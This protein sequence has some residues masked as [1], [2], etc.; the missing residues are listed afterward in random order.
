VTASA[1]PPPR[2]PAALGLADLLRALH[3][4]DGD[5]ARRDRA[6]AELGYVMKPQVPVHGRSEIAFQ[7]R[8]GAAGT[9]G[10][11]PQAAAGSTPAAPALPLWAV[12]AIGPGLPQADPDQPDTPL[13]ADRA[14]EL[15][16]CAPL[17]S[18]PPP[19]MP[20]LIPPARL[21]A[22]VRRSL[23]VP[24][25]TG[26]DVPALV[27]E[28]SRARLPTRLP[29]QRRM[30]RPGAIRVLWDRG[31]TML[32]YWDDALALLKPL[33]RHGA[34]DVWTLRDL[35]DRAHGRFRLRPDGRPEPLPMPSPWLAATTAPGVRTL[36]FSH[37]GALARPT[38]EPG[39]S[40]TTP[41]M[42][43][44][45]HWQAFL[46][47]A[48]SGGGRPDALPVAWVPCAPAGVG[49]GL[50]RATAVHS[51]APGTQGRRLRPAA[52]LNLTDTASVRRHEQA[53]ARGLEALRARLAGAVHVS[54]ALLRRLRLL[55]VAEKND[56]QPVDLGAEPG[57]EG[58]LWADDGVRRVAGCITL[59]ALSPSAASAADTLAGASRPLKLALLRLLTHE[60][61]HLGQALWAMEWLKLDALLGL[62]PLP[63]ELDAQRTDALRFHQRLAALV[64][65]GDAAAS[66]AGFKD[67]ASYCADALAR[68]RH[69]HRL[70]QHHGELLAPI[71]VGAGAAVGTLPPGLD[72]AAV[73]RFTLQC[74]QRAPAVRSVLWQQGEDLWLVPEAELGP[75][76]VKGAT[77]P[78]G[79]R[80]YGPA[81]LRE[82]SITGPEG[83]TQRFAARAAPQHLAR[84]PPSAGEVLKLQWA[85]ETLTLAA[86]PPPPWARETGRDRH[87]LYA[88][89]AIGEAVQRM[90]WIEPG[91]FWMGSPETEMFRGSDEGPRHRV[92]IASGYWLAD[93]VCT[94][95]FW[96]AAGGTTGSLKRKLKNAT[97]RFGDWQSHPVE[98]VSWHQAQSFLWQAQRIGNCLL[99]LPSEA[100][101][102]YACRAGTE[103]AY[104]FGDSLSGDQANFLGTARNGQAS[105][106]AAPVKTFAPNGW[107]LYGMHGNV[108]E[109]CEDAYR[110]YSFV[111]VT[112]PGEPSNPGQHGLRPTRGGSRFAPTSA[113]RSA[114]RTSHFAES[115]LWDHGF[116]FALR[117]NSQ[118]A[119]QYA[120]TLPIVP[121]YA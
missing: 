52:A 68:Q 44:Q 65:G 113:A 5:A 98:E 16:D 59:D 40:A 116:R 106:H 111:P 15:G 77:W 86:M 102:E 9:L 31:D 119:H 13:P 71:V 2:N 56:A 121:P 50:A 80:V 8:G 84:L 54:P 47:D 79:S 87:G 70:F 63:P 53:L 55:P 23:S 69:D 91:V 20:P 19:P 105:H 112:N 67:L 30:A 76:G 22:A 108:W 36:V 85:G 11:A 34:L 42:L 25:E 93:T 99:E 1:T 118:M 10:P 78:R 115:E 49:R 4:F 28:L 38:P 109:W 27:A 3:L 35:P 45:R 39:P 114:S 75:V 110:K 81:P 24:R 64:A 46:S 95:A 12:T 88:D 17:D 41:R 73:E 48:A 103:T 120:S 96:A 101:W 89:L 74:R 43:W 97:W 66:A 94:A 29:R 26:L 104:A 90:R 83:A 21:N 57:L 61:R 51:L 82:L 58:L 100:E 18:G 62:G 107:G 7:L 72:P 14:L 32:P 92:K 6:A 117:P 60:H 33:A 37:L